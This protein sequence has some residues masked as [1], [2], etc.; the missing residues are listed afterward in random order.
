[1]TKG[2][3]YG[4]SLI[5]ML[6][7]ATPAPARSA[8]T[9]AY[10]FLKEAGCQLLPLQ[11]CDVLDSDNAI[12][13]LRL[14]EIKLLTYHCGYS[15]THQAK[16]ALDSDGTLDAVRCRQLLQGLGAIR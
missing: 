8:G 11:A 4:L 3:F 10:N 7:V 2:S 14:Y 15:S 9:Y 12:N 16:M 13:I 5:L 1:M 6:G